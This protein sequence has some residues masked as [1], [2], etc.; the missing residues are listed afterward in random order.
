MPCDPADG[1]ASLLTSNQLCP[2][3]SPHARTIGLSIHPPSHELTISTRALCIAEANMSASVICCH[4]ARRMLLSVPP[5]SAYTKISHSDLFLQ[6]TT[7]G[8]YLINGNNMQSALRI[9]ILK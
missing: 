1:A 6:Y 9:A 7:H 3:P 5:G 2:N 4:P 8:G